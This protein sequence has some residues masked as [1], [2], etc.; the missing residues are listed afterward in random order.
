MTPPVSNPVDEDALVEWLMGAIQWDLTSAAPSPER[1]N[2]LG[3]GDVADDL[4]QWVLA[5]TRT[6]ALARVK[7][8]SNWRLL[9]DTR[10]CS[11]TVANRKDGGEPDNDSRLRWTKLVLG[12]WHRDTI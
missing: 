8:S 5:A 10:S 9:R 11:H 4:S 1:L 6:M 12:R 3:L 2:G 7:V